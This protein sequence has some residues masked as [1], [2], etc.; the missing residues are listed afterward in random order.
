VAENRTILMVEHNLSVVANLC[1]WITVLA[2]GKIL[3]EGTYETVSKDPQ[4][5]EAYIGTGDA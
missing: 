3:A 5:V 2:R 1:H 4:V